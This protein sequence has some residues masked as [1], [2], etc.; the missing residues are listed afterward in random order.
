MCLVL[1]PTYS[2]GQD[3]LGDLNTSIARLTARVT[4][5]VVQIQS[6]TYVPAA[7]DGAATSVA[8][9]PTTGSGVILSE[10]GFI[11]TNAHVVEGATEIQVQLAFIDG[12]SGQSVVRPRG[13]RLVAEVIGID[14]ETDLAVLKIDAEG[15]PTLQLADSEQIRQGQLVLAFGSPLG[16]ENSVSMGVVSSVAR[17]LEPDDRMIYIQTDAPINPG[18][19]G[20]P[21]VDV[22]G[23][24]IGIST[25][26]FSRSGGSD[27]VGFAV[28]SNIVVSVTD[29]LREQGVFRRGEIGVEAQTMMK[30]RA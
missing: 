22:S 19:S 28:P 24:V 5:A 4:P 15:L 13:R 26:I 16:L 21:L 7:P 10:D 30:R 18:N 17:Q 9:R 20:G 23:N 2:T 14:L 8:L 3:A 6:D 12:P 27:G 29:Q 11:V 25:M 1:F